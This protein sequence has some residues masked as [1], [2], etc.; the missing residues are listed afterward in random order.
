[1]PAATERKIGIKFSILCPTRARPEGVIR[2]VESICATANNPENIEVLFYVDADDSTFPEIKGFSCEIKMFKGPRVWISNAQNYLYVQSTGEIIMTAAD[3]MVFRTNKWDL[4]VERSFA[5]IADKI[6]LVFGNDLGTHAGKIAT[7][8]FFHK[9]WVE[10]L[11]TWVQPGRGSLWDLWATENARIIGRLVYRPELVIEHVHYRQS[12]N[13][14]EFD[15][16]YKTVNLANSSFRPELTYKKMERD[17]RIDRIL[18]AE[19][20][21]IQPK[22]EPKYFLGSLLSKTLFAN[23]TLERRRRL[24]SLGNLQVLFSLI[25]SL[26]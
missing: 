24:A 12:A 14:V 1:L 21:L 16:T 6:A 26:F 9:T 20:M 23:S 10:T 4:E 19:K 18:L 2:L 13:S 15:E 3:D 8:G 17:R 25:K 11:G 22:L 7:H 5:E